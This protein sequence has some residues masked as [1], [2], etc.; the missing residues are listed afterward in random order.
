MTITTMMTIT[1]IL[2]LKWSDSNNEMK[3]ND[4][5]DNVTRDHNDIDDTNDNDDDY[6]NDDDDDNSKDGDDNDE[7]GDDDDDDNNSDNDDDSENNDDFNLVQ[8]HNLT[9]WTDQTYSSSSVNNLKCISACSR[10][11]PLTAHTFVVRFT[12]LRFFITNL[13]NFDKS[14]TSTYERRF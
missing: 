1:T 2:L 4:N 14:A 9:S 11:S 6:S 7:D 3:N 8:F 13:H 12:P 5:E 10:L